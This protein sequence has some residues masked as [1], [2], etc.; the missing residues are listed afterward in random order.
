MADSLQEHD[1]KEKICCLW[2]FSAAL[3]AEHVKGCSQQ[4]NPCPATWTPLGQGEG[5][6]TERHCMGMENQSEGLLSLPQQL[7][8]HSHTL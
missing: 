4:E 2:E 6:G 5:P 1:S 7:Q 3:S 8:H